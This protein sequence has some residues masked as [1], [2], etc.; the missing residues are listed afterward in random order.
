LEVFRVLEEAGVPV[1]EYP[2]TAARMVPATKLFR[3]AVLD[4]D[5]T[6]DGHPAL[7]RH[8]GNATTKLTSQGVMLDKKTAR[9]HIDALVCSVFGY[10]I[11]TQRVEE[12]IPAAS[13]SPAPAQSGN[14]FRS[15][16]R[17]NI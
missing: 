6:H 5:F 13:G 17:L 12:Q 7:A 10:D 11:A 9:A 8:A 2:N 14:P 1:V 3:D 16:G 15:T 4:G